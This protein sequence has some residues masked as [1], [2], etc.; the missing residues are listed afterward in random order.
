MYTPPPAAIWRAGFPSS[1]PIYP[2]GTGPRWVFR[3]LTDR[4]RW[5]GSQPPHHPERY[6]PRERDFP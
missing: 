3:R 4:S 5:A 2:V 6:D 1:K